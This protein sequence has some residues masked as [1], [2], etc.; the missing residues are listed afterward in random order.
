M[1][2]AKPLLPLPRLRTGLESDTEPRHATW[3]ELFCDL[4]FVVAVSQ[5]AHSLS[6]DVSPQGFFTFA[7]LFVPIWWTWT[8]MTF[9]ANRFDSDDIGRR[10][11]IGVQMLAVAGMAVNV[12]HG[13]SSSSA[14][15]A[16]SYAA[17]RFLLVLEYLWAGWHI[18]I[19]RGLTTRYAMGFAIAATL[20]AVSVLFPLPLRFG[21]WVAGAI[22]DFTTPLTTTAQQRQLMPHPEHLPE[23][24]GLFTI[25][26][27]GEAIIAVVNGVYSVDWSA[28]SALVAALGFA[29]AFSLWWVYFENV[30]G[31]ALIRAS[32][33]GRLE[34]L[35]LW[36]YIHLP[37]A[38]GLA[39][40]G[41]GVEHAITSAAK[42]VLPDRERWLLCGAVGLCY[43]SLSLLHRTGMIFK[44]KARSRHRLT[45]V[46]VLLL[47]AIAGGGLSGLAV[48]AIV[49]VVALSQVGLD[50]YQGKPALETQASPALEETQPA[51][52]AP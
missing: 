22:V 11:S 12:H 31:A 1:S 44:C 13:L 8:G 23:R 42:A 47:V 40:A 24:F 49:A 9:Y 29:I 20:W 15:F 27:L 50:V 28:T 26:V 19:A 39:A 46:G 3:L 5:L 2:V 33:T 10:I 35:Q 6:Q 45:A 14:G 37:L 21:L 17:A 25:V 41:V 30:S 34:V 4:V 43:L 48:T 51:T 18:P 38:I 7:V 52:D 16:L 36:L 32:E